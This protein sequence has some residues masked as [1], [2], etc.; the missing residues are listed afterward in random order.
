MGKVLL[1]PD[2]DDFLEFMGF[3]QEVYDERDGDDE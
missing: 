1:F 3:L 2:A